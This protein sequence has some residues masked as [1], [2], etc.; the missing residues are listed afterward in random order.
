MARSAETPPISPPPTRRVE[1]EADRRWGCH[2]G[3]EEGEFLFVTKPNL[4]GVEDED[5]AG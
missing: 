1:T 2:M 4:F 3:I 5:W